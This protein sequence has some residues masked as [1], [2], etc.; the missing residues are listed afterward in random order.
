[1]WR[2]ILEKSFHK[3]SLFCCKRFLS[4]ASHITRR[5][6]PAPKWLME[7]SR[8]L[9]NW[10]YTW[11]RLQIFFFSYPWY[12]ESFKGKVFWPFNYTYTTWNKGTKVSVDFFK[13][14][15]WEVKNFIFLQ[16]KIRNVCQVVISFLCFIKLFPFINKTQWNQTMVQKKEIPSL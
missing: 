5:R 6:N 9:Q 7:K 13:K 8:N 12:V 10:F 2:N 3:K 11:T 4:L 14:Y 15:F 16:I 1:M